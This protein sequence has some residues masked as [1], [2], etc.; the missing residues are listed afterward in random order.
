M[1]GTDTVQLA[2]PQTMRPEGRWVRF[3]SATSLQPLG[4]G[5][6]W[7]RMPMLKLDRREVGNTP[8]QCFHGAHTLC[9]LHSSKGPLESRSEATLGSLAL[10]ADDSV[11]GRLPNGEPGALRCAPDNLRLHALASWLWYRNSST[12]VIWQTTRLLR[13]PSSH[14][15]QSVGK[16]RTD[17]RGS[18][19]LSRSTLIEIDLLGQNCILLAEILNDLTGNMNRSPETPVARVSSTTFSELHFRFLY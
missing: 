3:V 13:E 11:P 1:A 6:A 4:L 9:S 5:G 16:C 18:C 8:P 17:G 15:P 2:A 14:V 7:R 10:P 12:P 19:G